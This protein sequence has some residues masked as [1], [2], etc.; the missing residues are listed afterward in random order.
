MTYDFQSYLRLVIN[1][2]GRAQYD[3]YFANEY[4]RIDNTNTSGTTPRH[5]VTLHIVDALPALDEQDAI[6][7]KRRF[8]KLFTFEF[9]LVGLGT[10]DVHI[11]FKDH[12]VSRLYVT[13]VGVFLQAQV[14]EPAM[15]LSFLQQDI[16]FMHSAGVAKDG[17]AYLF[18]AYGGTGKTT[19]SM[20]LL[21]KGYGFLG[22]DLIIVDPKDGMAFP[23]PRPLHVF[24]YNIRNLQGAQVPLRLTSVVYFK[25]VLRFFLETFLRTE[26][27]ISTRVHADEILKDFEFSAPARLHNIIF[28][29]KEGAHE[30]VVFKT[31]AD[32]RTYAKIIAES[33]DLNE[34]LFDLINNEGRISEIRE[35]EISVAAAMLRRANAFSF[36]NT[37]AIDLAKV[38]KFLESTTPGVP[39]M[40][41]AV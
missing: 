22:D 11:Y 28:L 1:S 16:F 21:T 23:Y 2:G 20:G 34:S 4:D 40:D 12:P 15:Y 10:D 14:L 17:K 36:L 27:L 31:E 19:T 33:A 30:N 6:V 13:A 7:Q 26:F 3:R 32:F 39:E 38:E 29:K 9:A 24:T 25:N 37:R 18:P 8:K 41:G 35:K 5:R